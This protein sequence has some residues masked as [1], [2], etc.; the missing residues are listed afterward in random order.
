MNATII[1]DAINPT[2]GLVQMEIAEKDYGHRVAK[3]DKISS[4]KCIEVPAVS[5]P[6][7]LR[8]LKWDRISL[9]KIDIEGHEKLLL[10]ENASWLGMV[11]AMCVE[12]H[13]DFTSNDLRSLTEP[14]GFLPPEQ[15]PGIW[16]VRRSSEVQSEPPP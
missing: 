7:L 10:S 8:R 12:C 16:L 15:L 13:D 14:F 11:D 3:V 9:L 2:D 5:I 6:T 4:R 1:S